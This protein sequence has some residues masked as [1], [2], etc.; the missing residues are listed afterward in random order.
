MDMPV[1]KPV[2]IRTKGA[3]VLRRIW[4]WFSS[5][6]KWEVVEDFVYDAGRMKILIPKGFVFDGASIPRIFWWFL[7][8]TGLL[9][10][11]G[12]IHDYAYR[13]NYLWVLDNAGSRHIR[14]GCKT[15]WDRLFWKVGTQVNGVH[16]ANF[17]AWVAVT[18]GGWAAWR[19]NRA[20]ASIRR[21]QCGC[22]R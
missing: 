15:K 10:I 1:L 5:T 6:R 8:P 7:S 21:R 9:L 4:I 22:N 16:F 12:L 3:G 19:K 20:L 14:T 13:Y 17:V 2:A 11:P 18:V